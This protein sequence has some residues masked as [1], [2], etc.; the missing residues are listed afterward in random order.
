MW[1]DAAFQDEVKKLPISVAPL[2][3]VAP[4]IQ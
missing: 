4:A 2:R 1:D 3:F